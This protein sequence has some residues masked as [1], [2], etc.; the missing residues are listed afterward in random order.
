MLKKNLMH[1]EGSVFV[2]SNNS[3]N[4]GWVIQ[5]CTGGY[6]CGK[7]EFSDSIIDAKIYKKAV[8]ATRQIEK[9]IHELKFDFF[10][11]ENKTCRGYDD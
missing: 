4:I 8:N 1:P 2:V 9:L 3:G 5:S 10:T 6:Y 7:S 11:G